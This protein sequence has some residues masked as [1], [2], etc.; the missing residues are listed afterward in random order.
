MSEPLTSVLAVFVIQF[1]RNT[2]QTEIWR[3]LYAAASRYRYAGRWIIAIDDDIDPKSND[4]VFWAMSYRC[5]PQYDLKLADR[6]EAGHG[7]RNPRDDGELSA[8]LIN[9]TLKAPFPPVALP[10][11]EFMEVARALWE[12]LGLP[13]LRR[14]PPWHGYDL[15]AWTGELE[16]QARMAAEGRYFAL[17]SELAR[18]RRGSIGMNTPIDTNASETIRKRR[19]WHGRCFVDADLRGNTVRWHGWSGWPRC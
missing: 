7:P 6:K 11:R 12:R 9:A 8:V 16:R 2:P 1:R 5:Q 19:N 18:Q 17:G 13:K 3:G 15:G 10:G 4:A 14:E